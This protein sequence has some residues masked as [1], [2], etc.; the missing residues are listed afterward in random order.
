MTT[1]KKFD[2]E[3]SILFY[4]E[5]PNNM[6]RFYEIAKSTKIPK[7]YIRQFY[8][9]QPVNQILRKP[10]QKSKYTKITCPF[11]QPGCIQIDLMD[12]KKDSRR[13]QGYKYVFVGI[14]VFS[15]YL[16]TFP[17]KKKTPSSILPHLKAMIQDFRKHYPK[18]M[19][20][21][22]LD[23]GSEF[24]GGVK[25]YIK[26]QMFSLFYANPED[27]TKNRTMIVERVIRTIRERLRRLMI[28]NDSVKWIDYLKKVTNDYNKEIHSS[29]GISPDD[30]FI[31]KLP[32]STKAV[33]RKKS[34]S[35]ASFKTGDR[36]RILEKKGLFDKGSEAN[37]YTSTIYE[38]VKREGDRYTIKNPNNGYILR[39]TV[40]SREMLKAGVTRA[41]LKRD[42]KIKKIRKVQQ[43]S[44]RTD[45]MLGRTRY[46][47][48]LVNPERMKPR[49]PRRAKVRK[50]K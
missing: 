20:S 39:R 10:N 48:E 50:S 27:G 18:A 28:I 19:V 30:A 15:R 4:T 2:D 49:K 21:I 9:A 42:A 24:K 5:V 41:P 26:E 25:K 1:N 45:R 13:N 43:T 29:I 23:D 3:L 32:R 8:L 44:R 40:L 31:K 14:D 6:T 47:K 7:K 33:V 38:V 35:K 34:S 37:K 22:T 46:E 17:I 11:Q 16:W 12:V 36:V